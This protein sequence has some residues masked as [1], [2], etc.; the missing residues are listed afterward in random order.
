M[1]AFQEKCIFPDLDEEAFLY[2][3]SK[4]MNTSPE[5]LVTTYVGIDRSDFEDSAK[6]LVSV[7]EIDTGEIGNGSIARIPH[8]S[9]NHT[10]TETGRSGPSPAADFFDSVC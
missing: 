2:K 9:Q 7:L 10:R 5:Q 1:K 4:V 6:Q 3:L 8:G